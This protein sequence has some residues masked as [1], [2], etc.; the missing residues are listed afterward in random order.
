VTLPRAETSTPRGPRDR[1]VAAW[2]RL[3]PVLT[4]T[5]ALGALVT[6]ASWDV[7][8][9]PALSGLDPS[10]SAGMSMAAHFRLDF[11]T[12]VIWTYG[13]LGFLQLPYTH[14]SDLAVL[15][16]CWRAVLLLAY[17]LSLI[18]ALRRSFG[19]PIAVGVTFVTV[20]ALSSTFTVLIPPA[21]WCLAALTKD[22]PPFAPRLVSIGGGAF[23]ALE[24]LVRLSYGPTILL[25]CA[26]TLLVLPG[27]R[28]ELPT[29]A[30][31]AVVVFTV[32]WFA[33]GQG[34][35]N[36]LDFVRSA[37]EIVFGY[38]EAMGADGATDVYVPLAI[39]TSILLVGASA[40]TS[41]PG[42]YR[43]AAAVVMALPTFSLFKEAVV[44]YDEPHVAVFFATAT[45]L[46]M[47]VP[48]RGSWRFVGVP[49]L[50][51]VGTLALE[52]APALT[53]RD[54]NLVTH[55]KRFATGVRTLVSPDRR[56]AI[57]A[58]GRFAL[59]I[60]YRLERR[61]VSLLRGHGV[62]VDPWEA[63]VVWAFGLDWTPLPVFQ[64]YQAYTPELDADNADV[65]RS[66]SGPDRILR[67]NVPRL[68]PDYRTS[69]I[70]GR[71]PAWDPP[72]AAIAM[73]CHF[74]PLETTG[75][76][77]VLGRTANRCGRA[78]LLGS[79]ESAF[80]RTIPVPRAGQGEA[81]FARVH[82]AGVSGLE[83]L[84]SLLFRAR[85]R[86]VVVNGR[87]VWRLVPA[88]AADGLLMTVPRAADFPGS[89]FA[90]SPGART[91]SFSGGSG[92]LRVDFYAM[93]VR[94]LD[95]PR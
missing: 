59:A 23:G 13:P 93:R 51:A 31:T 5:W 4:S 3:R 70:D 40:V 73:L 68:Q 11:G 65:L 1:L 30:G 63:G 44:R 43:V 79:V 19:A 12:E 56:A 91:I 61:T 78:R 88:T 57:V 26:A 24:C 64:D 35:G 83:K 77:Q 16:F 15:S 52:T 41:A 28:R 94:A 8:F 75:R 90:L 47:A 60:Q 84:R 71:F 10:W 25:M 87:A 39:V 20:I 49:I 27:R 14:Y 21:V 55:V 54:F 50:L 33:A 48:W 45:P 22:P 67:A 85:F 72:Q 95:S 6:M 81:V 34:V 36:F 92:T 89:A 86:F 18:W 42:R 74:S 7:V 80:G 38:S 62:H 9:G 76:W 58:Q 32:L 37:A 29:F 69:A 2:P 46:L 82:G 17:C 66:D 53:Q